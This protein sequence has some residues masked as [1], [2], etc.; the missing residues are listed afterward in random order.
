MTINDAANEAS[1]LVDAVRYLSFYSWDEIFE[2][3][4]DGE[5]TRE[6]IVNLIERISGYSS[7][8]NYFFK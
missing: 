1:K 8:L 6:E 5:S 2:N 4:P 7:K 3:V